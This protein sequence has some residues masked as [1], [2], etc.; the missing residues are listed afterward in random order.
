MLVINTPDR[1]KINSYMEYCVY[2]KQDYRSS[3]ATVAVQISM[4]GG[5]TAVLG[6]E[7]IVS[8]QTPPGHPAGG[9]H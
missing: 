6:L 8:G 7:T 4:L 1:A 5:W 2:T 3:S 9:L